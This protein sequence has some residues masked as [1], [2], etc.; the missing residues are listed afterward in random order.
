MAVH[1][2][3]IKRHRQS[4]KRHARNVEARTKLRSLIKK[5]RQAVE[6]KNLDA[7]LAQI[8]AVN[9]ALDKAVNK[10]TITRNTA[11]R[12]LS[13]LSRSASPAA[14]PNDA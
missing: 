7:A 6:S 2:S 1:L 5:A 10:G 9:R 11:S 13:R 4:E 8:R 14:T 3:V 12:W